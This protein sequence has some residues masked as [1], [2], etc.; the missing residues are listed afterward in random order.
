MRS[1]QGRDR[2]TRQERLLRESN[3]Q[4][5]GTWCHQPRKAAGSSTLTSSEEGSHGTKNVA[6]NS[7]LKNSLS[8]E[9]LLKFPFHHSS[10]PQLWTQSSLQRALHPEHPPASLQPGLVTSPRRA[11]SARGGRNGSGALR[12]VCTHLAFQFEYNQFLNVKIHIKAKL[13]LQTYD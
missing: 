8:L 3:G 1:P 2:E 7:S 4:S 9:D 6:G 12:K 10:L 13:D 5:A 11:S